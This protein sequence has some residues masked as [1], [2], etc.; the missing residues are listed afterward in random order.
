[1]DK[2]RET[3]FSVFSLKQET[4]HPVSL[5]L[6]REGSGPFFRIFPVKEK[7]KFLRVRS[8]Q[9]VALVLLPYDVSPV[10]VGLLRPERRRWGSDNSNLA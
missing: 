6:G 5:V 9:N 7:R 8:P 4:F 1:M 10:L 2:K 3:S